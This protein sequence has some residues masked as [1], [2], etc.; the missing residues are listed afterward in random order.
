M[1]HPVLVHLQINKD[2]KSNASV[3]CMALG[4][5]GIAATWDMG[6][7]KSQDLT[8]DESRQCLGCARVLISRQYMVT[9][10]QIRY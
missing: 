2:H 10:I 6:W 9:L 1:S 3:I 8:T 7:L 5:S 4:G